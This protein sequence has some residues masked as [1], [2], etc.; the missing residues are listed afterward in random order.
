MILIIILL[1]TKF[2]LFFI[3]L[4]YNL[5]TIISISFYLYLRESNSMLDIFI[6]EIFKNTERLIIHHDSVSN[7]GFIGFK[8]FQIRS[9]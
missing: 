7:S 4:F 3:C 6:V 5:T 2:K 8:L 9:F 1:G